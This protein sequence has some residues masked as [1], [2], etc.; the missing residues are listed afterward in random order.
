MKNIKLPSGYVKVERT[1]EEKQNSFS[2][3]EEFMEEIR[4]KIQS[5]SIGDAIVKSYKRAKGK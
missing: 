4:N 2:I 1:E 5:K 3:S